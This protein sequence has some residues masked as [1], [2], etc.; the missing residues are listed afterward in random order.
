MYIEFDRDTCIG[1]FQCVSEWEGFQENRT[2][3]KAD[4]RGADEVAENVFVRA[5][6]DDAETDAKW[7]ARVCPVDAITMYDDDGTQL[8]P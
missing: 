4:L 5:I 8:I 3:G 6:P 1:A 2:D 7:A